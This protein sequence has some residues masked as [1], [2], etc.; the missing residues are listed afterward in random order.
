MYETL[1]IEGDAQEELLLPSM[2]IYFFTR[3]VLIKL[4][5]NTPD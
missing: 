2:G 1:E 3:D 5:D 4:L